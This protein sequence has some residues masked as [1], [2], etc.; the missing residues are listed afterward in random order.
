MGNLIGLYD[1][2][3]RNPTFSN[4]MAALRELSIRL[5]NQSSLTKQQI[6]VYKEMRDI[7]FEMVNDMIDGGTLDD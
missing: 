6:Q 4:I 3:V 2:A 5:D 7:L 1:A